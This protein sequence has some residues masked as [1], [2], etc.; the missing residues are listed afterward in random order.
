M[1]DKLTVYHGLAIGRNFNSVT[2]MKN[3]IKATYYHYYL[4]NKELQHNQCP[5]GD[6]SWCEWQ[7]D[8]WGIGSC[9]YS[10]FVQT[11]LEWSSY[12]CYNS[13]KANL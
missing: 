9:K 11:Q 12:R 4:I 8:S 13:H 2:K 5:S 3:A 1:I 6:D 7:V 10:A